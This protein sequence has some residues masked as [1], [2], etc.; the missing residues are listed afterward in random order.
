MRRNAGRA[1]SMTNRVLLFYHSASGN[2][3][4][5]AEAIAAAL[6]DRGIEAELRSI[7]AR[8]DTADLDSYDLVGFGCPVMGFRPSFALNRFIR[9]LPVQPHLPAFIFTTHA[10]VLANAPWMLAACL[11]DRGFAVMA[12]KH[13]R[14]EI[15]WPLARSAGLI[16]NRGLPDDR[17]LPSISAFAGNLAELA[18]RHR[19]GSP[20]RSIPVSRSWLNPFYY[21]SLINSPA[22]LR[23]MM[24]TKRVII[25]RCTKCGLCAEH[26][27][28]GAI[29]LSPY[30][31][32]GSNCDGCWGCY[33]ICPAAAI[34]TRIGTRGRY[35]NQKCAPAIYSRHGAGQ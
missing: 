9:S 29:A 34:A 4:W 24:G 5:V 21:L 3:H 11:R 28:P 31:T 7:A 14:G 22:K 1:V 6:A 32:F 23:M 16:I 2:T 12:H 13:F 19:S 10:G 35:Y 27:A 25:T 30:P 33:N 17:L 15:S 20:V 18:A 8:H 26:C